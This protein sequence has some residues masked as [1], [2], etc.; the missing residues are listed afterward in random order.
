[1]HEI[2]AVTHGR[3]VRAC[4]SFCAMTKVINI[5]NIHGQKDVNVTRHARSQLSWKSSSQF[6]RHFNL[7]AVFGIIMFSLFDNE[8]SIFIFIELDFKE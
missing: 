4:S 1:M 3:P 8:I 6:K 7:E 5:W 2:D